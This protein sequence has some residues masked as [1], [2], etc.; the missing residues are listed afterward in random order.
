MNNSSNI[1]RELPKKLKLKMTSNPATNNT[2][3]IEMNNSNTDTV[4]IKRKKPKMTSIPSAIL[5]A[6]P[7]AI[8][9]QMPKIYIENDE[10]ISP[11]NDLELYDLM[12]HANWGDKHFSYI[13]NPDRWGCVPKKKLSF[14]LF[15]LRMILTPSQLD[16]LKKKY[17][18][19]SFK[20]EIYVSKKD[21]IVM[22]NF[23]ALLYCYYQH[24]DNKLL[25]LNALTRY[26]YETKM[27]KL[28]ALYRN[29]NEKDIYCPFKYCRHYIDR[30][31][32]GGV[33]SLKNH[34]NKCHS[35]LNLWD[36]SEYWLNTK[37]N[38]KIVARLWGDMYEHC[39][40]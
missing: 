35:E 40:S 38:R 12:T 6:T 5:S 21:D 7:S 26:D 31:K 3:K 34:L 15:K 10:E 16:E 20:P 37:I 4:V 13:F 17:N 14:M 1:I 11:F 8:P 24:A 32:M 27:E 29:V 39:P 33:R 23:K 2:Q 19:Q 9:Q 28:V 25:H 22:N 36:K 18:T 30:K